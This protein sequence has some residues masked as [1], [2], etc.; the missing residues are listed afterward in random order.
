M[1]NPDTNSWRDELSVLAWVVCPCCDGEGE[2]YG[3][4]WIDS[5]GQLREAAYPCVDC[6]G[7][8]LVRPWEV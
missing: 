1:M 2:V 3:P 8:G 4:D 7:G 5:E 6:D